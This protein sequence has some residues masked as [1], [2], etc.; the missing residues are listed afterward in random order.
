MCHSLVMATRTSI[1]ASG[2]LLLPAALRHS[3]GLDVGT[4]VVVYAEDGR[5]IV[6]PWERSLANLQQE[7]QRSGE[8]PS[9]VDELIADRRADA[10]LTELGLT[11]MSTCR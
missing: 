9:L 11:V 8:A 4:E 7:W 10:A 5:L 3:L 1:G 6:E 2:R